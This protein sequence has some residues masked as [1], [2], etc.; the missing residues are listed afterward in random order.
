MCWHLWFF[1]LLTLATSTSPSRGAALWNSMKIS[2]QWLQD[3]NA[4]AGCACFLNLQSSEIF[5]WTNNTDE[6]QRWT[7]NSNHKFSSLIIWYQQERCSYISNFIDTQLIASTQTNLYYLS[8]IRIQHS[9]H[10]MWRFTDN[11]QKVLIIVFCL[12][13]SMNYS[14]LLKRLMIRL[15]SSFLYLDKTEN[16]LKSSKRNVKAT[17]ALQFSFNV[18]LD[19]L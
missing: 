14:W 16:G 11:E 7:S 19:L 15:L 8:L 17:K 4:F 1:F 10:M 18:N 12:I 6:L 9:G 13:F 5:S 3:L 2:S